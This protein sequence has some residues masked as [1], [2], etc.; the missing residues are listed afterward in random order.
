MSVGQSNVS[1]SVGQYLHF[2]KMSV[3][4]MPVGQMAFNQISVGQMAFDQM[5]WNLLNVGANII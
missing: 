5:T 3:S 2:G 4:Q 1:L